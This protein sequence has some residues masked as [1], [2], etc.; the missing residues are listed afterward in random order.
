[1]NILRFYVNTPNDGHPRTI[2]PTPVRL[3]VCRLRTSVRRIRIHDGRGVRT[4]RRL[5][6]TIQSCNVR[7]QYQPGQDRDPDLF[8]IKYICWNFGKPSWVCDILSAW[9]LM[10]SINLRLHSTINRKNITFYIVYKI[11]SSI[12]KNNFRLTFP[13]NTFQLPEIKC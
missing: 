9:R 6:Q 2:A 7:I 1:M 3:R 8:F 4:I 13:Q 12:H 5:I 11:L 10:N